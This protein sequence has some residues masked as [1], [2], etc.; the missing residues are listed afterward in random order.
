M[1]IEWALRT[2]P[3]NDLMLYW[4]GSYNHAKIIKGIKKDDSGIEV[5]IAEAHNKDDQPLFVPA[6]NSFI[7]AEY[8][9]AS[10]VIT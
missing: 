9:V 7:G 10:F 5:E 4:N 8:N 1:G 6:I 3:V 2:K